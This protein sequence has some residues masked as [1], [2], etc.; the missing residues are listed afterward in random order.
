MKLTPTLQEIKESSKESS[1]R[2]AQI[3]R[4]KWA[5][6]LMLSWDVLESL[7]EDDKIDCT[8]D[9]CGLCQRFLGSDYVC[10]MKGEKCNAGICADLYSRARRDLHVGFLYKRHY[11][12]Q[13]DKSNIRKMY[14]FL[15]DLEIEELRKK[16]KK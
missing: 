8:T 11:S 7:I 13:D 3:S 6:F 4:R 12:G 10:P 1:F 9:Y 2:A 5:T 16:G 15:M 14:D